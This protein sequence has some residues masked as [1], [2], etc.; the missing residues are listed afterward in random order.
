MNSKFIIIA[1]IMIIA[2]AFVVFSLISFMRITSVASTT[3]GE[4]TITSEESSIL[5]DQIQNISQEQLNAVSAEDP[6]FLSDI[7][8][9]IV[10]D[11]SIFYYE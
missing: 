7:Q 5:N 11:M 4:T 1:I 6:S 8:N 2:L 10:A 9:R 3:T